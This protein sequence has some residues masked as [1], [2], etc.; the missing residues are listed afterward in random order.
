MVQQAATAANE[1]VYKMLNGTDSVEP[2]LRELITTGALNTF[3]LTI[4]NSRSQ[5]PL[6]TVQDKISFAAQQALWGQLLVPVWRTQ[7]GGTQKQGVA[8]KSNPF[9]L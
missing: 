6:V 7:K 9:I 3:Y 1:Y 2:D 5:G 4:R 8:K